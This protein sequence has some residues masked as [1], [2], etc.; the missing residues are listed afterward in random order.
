M[1]SRDH[2]TLTIINRKVKK[3][4]KEGN[5]IYDTRDCKAGKYKVCKVYPYHAC[6]IDCNGF[7][8][9]FTNSEIAMF[10]EKLD[11]VEDIVYRKEA[12]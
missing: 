12:V 4:C 10:F 1:D 11:K 3:I 6:F 2:L 8:T 5:I 9:S 7:T